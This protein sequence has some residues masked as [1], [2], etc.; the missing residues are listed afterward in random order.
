M[1]AAR[2][3]RG[4]WE[5]SS[6]ST[7]ALKADSKKELAL[8]ATGVILCTS[9]AKLF[10]HLYAS[11]HYGYFVD[12]L[13]YL[14]CSRHLDWGYVDQPPLIALIAWLERVLLGDS[15]PAIRFLPAVAGAGEVA[16]TA[17]LA[18][19][20][21]GKR[22]AQGLAA[23]AALVPPAILATDNLLSMNAFE[24]L[25]WMGCAYLFIRMVITGNQR[26]WIWFG[27]LAGFGLENKYSMLIFGAGIVVGLLLTRDRRWL[28]SPWIWIGGAV[29][30]LI[31][32]PNLLWN[33][34][35]HFPFLELQANIRRSGRDVPLGPLRFFAEEILTLLPLTLSIWLAGLWFFFFS[36][37]G[38]AFRVLGWAWVFSAVVIV[39]LSPRVYYLYPAFP[40]LLANGSVMWESWL[41]KP[42]YNWLKLTYPALMVLFGALSSPLAIP[43]LPPETYIR[44]TKA[45]HLQPPRIET[46]KLG[47]LPQLYADQFGWEEM[48]ATVA[49][50]YNSLPPEARAKTAIF[51]QNYGQAGAIDLFGPKYGLPPA[52]SGHQS[53]FLWGPH[54]Y[55]GE[56]M[57][58]MQGQQRDLERYYTSVEK[59]A[60]VYH[61]H[62]MPYEHFDIYYCRGLRQPLK[63][64][65]PLVKNWD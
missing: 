24:P 10:V 29:A 49:R 45:T 54:C 58:V 56:S 17:L 46:H 25:F 8:T 34:Q 53:Y 9:A 60:S 14:A 15:L 28:A 61:P 51:G 32:L 36:K 12:E 65:W 2:G 13:Y 23:L 5:M 52:I 30:F 16:L 1:H 59:V 47:P 3:P 41:E 43:I 27:V 18:R 6:S 20:L 21:G 22:F 35:H 38:K 11:H 19:E 62:S 37:L 31:F 7:P 40:V 39:T 63:E 4:G 44:Y 50:V 64:I 33:I 55:T 26:L 48:V 42:R 57:I